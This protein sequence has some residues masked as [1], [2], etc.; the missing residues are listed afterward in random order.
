MK[1]DKIEKLNMDVSE[2]SA[3]AGPFDLCVS[4]NVDECGA[5]GC[6]DCQDCQGC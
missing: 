4:N 6:R 2:G 5:R 3:D 1:I